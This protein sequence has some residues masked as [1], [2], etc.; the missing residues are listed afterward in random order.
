LVGSLLHLLHDNGQTVQFELHTQRRILLYG[1]QLYGVLVT[2]L[3]LRLTGVENDANKGEAAYY[4]QRNNFFHNFIQLLIAST[5]DYR[6]S[7]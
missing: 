2:T 5:C 6:Q 4:C 7:G 1:S 3:L